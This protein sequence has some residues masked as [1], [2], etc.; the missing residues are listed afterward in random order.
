M[1]NNNKPNSFQRFI[2][3]NGYYF[4][5]GACAL[6]IGV[7]GYFLLRSDNEPAAE[8]TLS[9]PVT[10]EPTEKSSEQ[11]I[12]PAEDAI[13]EDEPAE[14]VMAETPEETP[15]ETA[16]SIVPE[17]S[18]PVMRTVVQPVS[19][20]ALAPYSVSALSYQPTTQDWRIHD[21]IDL[22]ADPG[23][24]VCATEA[25][26]VTAVYRDDYLGMTVEIAHETGFTTIYSNLEDAV[27]VTA[28]QTVTAGDCIGTVGN[29]ALLE[30]GHPSHLHFAVSC[31]G[32]SVDPADYFA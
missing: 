5:I 28:G 7:S 25:G 21:G 1:Q 12:I 11:P 18:V 13:I 3:K 10:I 31:N 23:A 8:E 29:T 26:T 2:R 15:A 4:V 32:L 19:G 22:A 9:V 6:A 14:E 20:E 24:P 30:V 17:E 27:A 16:D